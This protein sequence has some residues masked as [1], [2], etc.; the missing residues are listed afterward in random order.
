[1]DEKFPEIKQDINLG[2]YTTFRVGGKVRWFIEV[3]TEKLLEEVLEEAEKRAISV[4]MIAGGSNVLVADDG[5]DGLVIANRIKGVEIEGNIV[6]AKSGTMWDEVVDAANGAG[7]SGLESTAGIPGTVGGM[8]YGNAGAYGQS[9][10]EKLKLVWVLKDG[11]TYKVAK[12]ECEFGYRE[13][14]F[15]S[16]GE[17]ILGAEW[18][19]ESGVR[20]LLEKRTEE[21][22]KGRREK[23]PPGLC[24]PGSF[25]KNLIAVELPE[26]VLAM[27]PPENIKGGQVPAGYLLE[28]VGA[29]GRRR[30]AAKVTDFHANILE[31]T[32][33]AKA[34]DIW[35]LAT[36]LKEDVKKKFGIEL[37]PEV[38]VI[39]EI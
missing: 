27:I 24:C 23:F 30:G 14:R 19:L 17:I 32:G 6:K 20:E 22:R 28:Q 38:R 34:S 10:S 15:I 31:N 26:S 36:E 12:K 39:G 16:S 29:K 7:L 25:F 21:I 9:V 2:Q 1:M 8:V 13:S 5:W 35:A 33:G 37:E 18:E 3:T 4:I 11:K